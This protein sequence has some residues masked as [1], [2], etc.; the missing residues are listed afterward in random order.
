MKIP[1]DY[2]YCKKVMK[3]HLCEKLT[4]DE[5]VRDYCHIMGK[6]RGAAH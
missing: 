6:Y 5:K 4:E 3:K 2:E 1:E